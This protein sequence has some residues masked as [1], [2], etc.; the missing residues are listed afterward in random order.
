M[1]ED[2]RGRQEKKR[3]PYRNKQ[4]R[5]G[6]KSKPGEHQPIFY[7]RKWHA[8]NL[9]QQGFNEDEVAQQMKDTF[10]AELREAGDDTATPFRDLLGKNTHP[11]NAE[12]RP[13]DESY[14]K[15]RKEMEQNSR[16]N[17][18]SRQKKK[19]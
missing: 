5:P 1:V 6:S 12:L 16:S 3:K 17:M 4:I 8:D 7:A 13:Y 10:L 11:Q 2:G 15:E 9:R 14:V 19:H 18:K